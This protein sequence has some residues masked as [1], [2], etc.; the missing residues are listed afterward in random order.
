MSWGED[1]AAVGLALAVLA[2]KLGVADELEVLRILERDRLGHRLLRCRFGELAVRGGLLGG[3]VQHLALV[4]GDLA[5]RHLPFFGRGRDQH[6]ARGSAGLA[7]LL[8]RDR[9]GVAAAGALHAAHQGAAVLLGVGRRA[10]DVDE[11]PVGVELF[12]RE[13]RQARERALAHL[14]VLGQDRHAVVFGD[15]DEGVGC[16]DVGLAFGLHRLGQRRG[17]LAAGRGGGLLAAGGQRRSADAHADG[18]AADALHEAA[19]A[20]VDGSGQ[21]GCGNRSGRDAIED[22]HGVVSSLLTP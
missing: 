9:H 16:E 2:R 19:A 20:E 13:R 6:R 15:A 7:H 21:G 12:G 4:G 14:E 17:F 18:E 10:F 3:R 5:R 1:G 8:V 22:A 11:I